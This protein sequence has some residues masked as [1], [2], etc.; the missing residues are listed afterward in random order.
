MINQGSRTIEYRSIQSLADSL[1]ESAGVGFP[2]FSFRGYQ[3]LPF[4]KA[5]FLG[6]LPMSS[7]KRKQKFSGGVEI[8]TKLDFT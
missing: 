5:F 1:V 4:W 8:A 2:I 6:F 3:S 7:G